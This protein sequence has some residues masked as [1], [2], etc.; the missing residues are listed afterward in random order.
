MTP[1][2]LGS[3][4]CGDKTSGVGPRVKAISPIYSWFQPDHDYNSSPKYVMWDLNY[5][6]ILNILQVS[7]CWLQVTAHSLADLPEPKIQSK[8]YD[9][10]KGGFRKA[11]WEKF[12]G[13][14]MEP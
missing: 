4:A 5:F 9:C 3:F 8:I 10:D 6:F 13:A 1:H 7:F 12:L 11:I 2:V 14:D